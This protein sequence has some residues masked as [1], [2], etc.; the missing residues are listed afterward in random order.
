MNMTD[1]KSGDFFKV[2]ALLMG[3]SIS[4]ASTA[5]A[6]PNS[7]TYHYLPADTL[8]E[9]IQSSLN[10]QQIDVSGV[11]IVVDEQG[12]VRVE[13]EVSSKQAADNIVNTIAH[14]DGVYSTYTK[15]SYP[16]SALN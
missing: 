4:F 15:L 6:N 7:S 12:Y 11:E 2:K 3:L 14:K 1:Q 10:E 8:K 16:Q 13:G 9:S 5:F